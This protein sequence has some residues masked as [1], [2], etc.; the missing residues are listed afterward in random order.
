M[1]N[2]H[3]CVCCGADVRVV[4]LEQ[5][6]DYSQVYYISSNDNGLTWTDIIP[7][8][9]FESVKEHPNLSFCRNDVQVVWTDNRNNKYAI[10]GSHSADSGKTWSSPMMLS[11]STHVWVGYPVITH[12]DSTYHVVWTA[13]TS[14]EDTA[15]HGIFHR[16]SD[17]LGLT[18]EPVQ[19]L[20]LSKGDD[21]PYVSCASMKNNLHMAWGIPGEGMF[22]RMSTD[23]GITW[24]KKEDLEMPCDG[25]S[26]CI[27]IAAKSVHV[28]WYGQ[29]PK[30]SDLYYIR[31]PEGNPVGQVEE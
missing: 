21:L 30:G 13:Q 25:R 6:Q 2:L 8:T 1:P 4:W 17:D 28:V 24:G 3:G 18:W 20:V 23:N 12:V 27:A 5:Q 19:W 29:G 31:S 7:V 9:S 22:Y 16:R 26:P 10:W 11:L 14:Q 15:S